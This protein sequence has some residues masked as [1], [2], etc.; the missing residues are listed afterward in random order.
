[1]TLPRRGDVVRTRLR[2]P[3]M[4]AGSYRLTVRARPINGELVAENNEH[5]TVLDVRP[6]PARVLYVEGSPVRSS[7]SCGEPVAGD[8][9]VQVVGLMRSAEQKF[10]RLGVRDSLELINGFRRAAR[11]CSSSGRSSSAASSRRSSPATSSACC[12]SS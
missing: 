3:P 12:R 7:L 2:V 8:S 10:L 9:A 5:S 11:T 1:V 4:P 6:G